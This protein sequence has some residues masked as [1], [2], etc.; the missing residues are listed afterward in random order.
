MARS[1]LLLIILIN[2]VFGSEEFIFWADIG[3]T[4]NIVSSQKIAFSK[5]MVLSRNK[6]MNFLCE[7][8]AFKDKNMTTMEFL[9]FNKD[10]IFDCFALQKVKVSGEFNRRNNIITQTSN[11]K[12]YP[13]RFTIKFKPKSAIIGVFKSEESR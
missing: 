7:I 4:N 2:S 6:T 1:L 5:A 11:L 13:I 12:I 10:K 9:N 3:T 8:D